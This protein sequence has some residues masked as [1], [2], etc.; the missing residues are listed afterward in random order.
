MNGAGDG[1][2]GLLGMK[3]RAILC[4]GTLETGAVPGGGFAV[5]AR[6]PIHGTTT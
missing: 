5:R 1:G 2:H 3:E 6:L 4:G